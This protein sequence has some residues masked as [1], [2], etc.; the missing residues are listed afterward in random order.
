MLDR[1]GAL[2]QQLQVMWPDV[3]WQ[4]PWVWL[5]LPLPLLIGLIPPVARTRERALRFPPLFDV[6]E[7]LGNSRSARAPWW[8]LLCALLLWLGLLAASSRPVWIGPA[9]G[10]PVSGRDLMLAIDISGSM[11]ETDLYSAGNVYSRIDVV[12]KVGGDFI[13]RRAGDR[14]GLIM[15]GSQAYV[16]TPLTFDHQTVAHFMRE[17]QVGLAGRSTAIGDAIGLAVKRLRDRP[18]ESRV[19][20]LLTDGSNTAGVVDPLEAAQ[21]AANEDIRIHAIGVGA[22]SRSQLLGFTRVQR[23]ELDEKTLLQIA[24]LTGGEYFRARDVKE[25]ERIYDA[26]DELEP[27]D[28]EADQYR[29]QHELYAWP[30]TLVLLLSVV[31]AWRH[32]RVTQT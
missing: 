31:L 23:S 30:L 22:E 3:S 17:A 11:D 9:S 18:Q 21:I 7:M 27:T 8:V 19:I 2:F 24:S 1:L 4:L 28:S 5:L 20:V 14:L 10:T 16:Q 29:P 32:L 12:R 13:E 15:F 6:S 26:I 25:L